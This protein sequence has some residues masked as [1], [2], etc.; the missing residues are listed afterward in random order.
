MKLGESEEIKMTDENRTSSFKTKNLLPYLCLPL[1]F[2]VVMALWTNLPEEQ[3]SSVYRNSGVWDLRNFNFE[4][5]TASLHGRVEQLDGSFL[6]LQDFGSRGDEIVLVYPHVTDSSAVVRIRM[7]MPTDDYFAITRISTGYADRIFVN[8]QW[9]RDIG[10]PEEND[11]LFT[12]I[13]T[14]TARPVDGVIEIIHR[15]SNFIYHVHG[16]YI[17][18]TLDEHFLAN[19]LRRVE[20]TTNIVLGILLTLAVISLLLF[21]ISRN[22]WPALL[23]AVLCIVWLVYT[24]AMGAKVFTTIAPWHIDPL[25]FRLTLITTP[26]TPVL[27][28]AIIQFMYK[29]VFNK[30]FAR[31]TIIFFLAWAIFFMVANSEF[32]LGTVFWVCKGLV[33]VW[34]VYAIITLIRRRQKPVDAG[35]IIFIIGAICLSYSSIRDII[36]QL[37]LNIEGLNFLLPPFVGQNFSR[38]GVVALLLCQAVAIFIG[39]MQRMAEAQEQEKRLAAENAAAEAQLLAERNRNLEAD[40]AN[41]LLSRMNR[42]KAKFLADISH[43]IRTPL[44]VIDNY[45]QLTDMEIYAGLVGEDTKKNLLTISSEAQRLAHLADRLLDVTVARDSMETGVEVYVEDIF[46]RTLALCEPILVV[47]KNRL[48]IHIEK[49]C[50][51]VRVV[52]DMLIQVLFNLIGNANRHVKGGTIRLSAKAEDD[53][54]F[55]VIADKGTGISPDILAKVFERGVSSDGSSGLGLSICKEA[56]ESHGGTISVESEQ[57]EAGGTMVTFTLP[58]YA[59]SEGGLSNVN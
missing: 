6:E 16:I 10:N 3:F 28:M 14:F 25:R 31:G 21:S 53:M 55:F 17:P 49:N 37:Y 35:Q 18:G 29:G 40:E 12:P 5:A 20:F 33:G 4:N 47:N 52:P 24:G 41:K 27:I 43:E 32:V 36:S 38:V 50:P 11:T 26:I 8:G 59:S 58:I 48:D 56:I 1:I 42:L 30:H 34:V 45:A 9:L 57:G 22:Y 19:D 39:M 2:F 13:F 54:V 15:Q 44:T 7:I 23:F 51:S 46:S